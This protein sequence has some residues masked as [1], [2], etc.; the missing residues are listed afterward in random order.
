MTAIPTPARV[1]KILGADVELGNFVAGLDT[2]AGSGSV[3]SRLL[4]RQVRGIVA[5]G[6]TLAKGPEGW[7]VMHKIFESFTTSK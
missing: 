3:A 1:P 5:G 7:V 4:L 2:P 6:V